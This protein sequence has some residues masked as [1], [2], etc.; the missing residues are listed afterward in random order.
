MP[1]RR[2]YGSSSQGSQ[3]GPAKR[4]RVLSAKDGAGVLLPRAKQLKCRKVTS[5]TLVRYHAALSEF[6]KW[7]KK[8]KRG[9]NTHTTLDHS[10]VEYMRQQYEDGHQSWEGSYLVFGYQ[11]LRYTGVD[12]A[13]LPESKKA[14]KGWK[15]GAPGKMRLPFPEEVVLDVADFAVESQQGEAALAIALQLDGYFRPSEA[16][17]LTAGQIM[18]PA[19][20]AGKAYAKAWGV[21]LAPSEG[22]KPTKTGHF[23]DSVLIGDIQHE[24]LGPMLETIVRGKKP[25]DRIFPSLTLASYERLFR[26]AMQKR[27]N[28]CIHATPHSV[29]HSGPSND[30]FH[31]RRSLLQIQKRGRWASPK[32]VARYEKEALLLGIWRSIPECKHTGIAERSRDLP[33]KLLRLLQKVPQ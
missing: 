21:V 10:I 28:N 15:T 27:F 14:L 1:K 30:R 2:P 16:I 25:E 9:G 31:K 7:A 32:S 33:Q 23:D 8:N 3:G 4:G 5:N 29:R 11:L 19:R 13:C 12:S 17:Y 24:W 26:D 22:E 18:P 6:D 20:K